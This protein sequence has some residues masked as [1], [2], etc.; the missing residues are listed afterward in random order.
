MA[1]IMSEVFC[2]HSRE[3]WKDPAKK[4]RYAQKII[5]FVKPNVYSCFES[6][7]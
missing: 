3:D 5:V 6:T 2:P 7:L 1:T 4:S